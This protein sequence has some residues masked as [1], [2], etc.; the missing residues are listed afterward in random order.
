MILM[1]EQE[2]QESK[3]KIDDVPASLMARLIRYCY[4]EEYPESINSADFAVR[5]GACF[6]D[7]RPPIDGNDLLAAQDAVCLYQ[8]GDRFTV[9]ALKQ[10]AAEQFLKAW[11]RIDDSPEVY[12][13]IDREGRL[14]RFSEIFMSLSSSVYA[15]TR[16]GDRVLRDVVA[17]TIK[18]KFVHDLHWKGKYEFLQQFIEDEEEELVLDLCMYNMSHADYKCSECNGLGQHVRRP[19]GCKKKEIWCE[20]KTC[21]AERRMESFCMRCGSFGCLEPSLGKPIRLQ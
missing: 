18:N 4:T 10:K 8:V 15:A 9:P 6:I 1:N 3:V 13:A 19:C 14:L 7:E 20:E 12:Q 11:I 21:E 17:R 2:V 5:P 16:P